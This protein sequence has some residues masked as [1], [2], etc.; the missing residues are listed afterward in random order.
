MED[1]SHEDRYTILI[2]SLW[3][4]FRTRNVSH[5]CCG[6]IKTNFAFNN[7]KKCHS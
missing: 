5:K 6:E 2:T 7:K 1:T 3:I 4:L